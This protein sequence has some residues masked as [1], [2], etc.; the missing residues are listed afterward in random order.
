M[1]GMKIK[2]LIRLIIFV[3]SQ[4]SSTYVTIAKIPLK[5]VWLI[6]LRGYVV[7]YFSKHLSES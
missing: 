3:P 7:P 4:S 6:L 1:E 2:F 5:F